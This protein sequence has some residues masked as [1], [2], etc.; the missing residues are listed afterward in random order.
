MNVIIL[1]RSTP[2]PSPQIQPFGTLKGL[3]QS[4]NPQLM[5]YARETDV[6]IAA[7]RRDHRSKIFELYPS[8]A[9]NLKSQNSSQDQVEPYRE[10]FGHRVFLKCERIRLKLHAVDEKENLCQVEPYHTTL[11]LYDAK[12][13]RKLTENFHFDVNST[14]IRN[15]FSNGF[16]SE[17]MSYVRLELPQNLPS[18][19]LLYPRQALLSITNPHPDIF[20]VVRIE[21]VLQGGICQSSEPYVKAN[22]DPKIS[23]KVYKN[24]AV[25][26]HRL[27]K[28]RMPFAW[29]ARPLFR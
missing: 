8:L 5:R 4:M 2:P 26:C 14:S 12:N 19:W 18:E 1:E 11:C 22:K 29:A 27:G 13:G 28:Y 20:L 16:C 23:L 10:V 9:M 15:T 7:A 21:K 6:S 17:T 25:C 24:I 3:E